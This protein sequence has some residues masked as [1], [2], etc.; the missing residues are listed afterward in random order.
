M[1]AGDKIQRDKYPVRPENGGV[2]GVDDKNGVDDKKE[3][4]DEKGVDDEKGG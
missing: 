1:K 2:M 3:V 4:A